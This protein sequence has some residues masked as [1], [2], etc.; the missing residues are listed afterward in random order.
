MDKEVDSVL[1]GAELGALPLNS[2]PESATAENADG[3]I[4]SPSLSAC[5]DSLGKTSNKLLAAFL[6]AITTGCVSQG[7]RVSD[8][9]PRVGLWE[10]DTRVRPPYGLKSRSEAVNSVT[11]ITTVGEYNQIVAN[12]GPSDRT[13]IVFGFK[14]CDPCDSLVKE[15][16]GKS[17]G[18]YKMVYFKALNEKEFSNIAWIVNR[19]LGSS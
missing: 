4:K 17:T 12:L 19:V 11:R 5:A 15:W 10:L 18:G 14:D 1:R 8:G 7:R 16:I 13:M 2:G 3:L 9:D 6:L